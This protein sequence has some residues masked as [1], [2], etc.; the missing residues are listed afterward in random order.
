MNHKKAIGFEIRTIS[1]LIK[2][3]LE[4][5]PT[6]KYIDNLT[7]THGWIIGYLCHNTHK[8]IFQRDLENEFSI[9]RSTATGI[10]KLMEKNEL[11]IREPVPSDAR[12]KKIILTQKALDM[13]E[14]VRK[15]IKQLETQL[16]QGLSND[17]VEAFF[18]IIEKMKK[19]ME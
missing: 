2:R 16:I 13:H 17:E 18:S 11:I 4:K 8:D 19:N 14:L 1:N 6:K 10:L 12:L 7:G 15:D 3:N 5:S 9:R